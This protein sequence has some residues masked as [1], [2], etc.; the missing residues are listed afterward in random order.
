MAS[1]TS[2]HCTEREI[3]PYFDHSNRPD[4]TKYPK[5]YQE[6]KGEL[7]CSAGIFLICRNQIMCVYGKEHGKW[8]GP[9]G[10]KE[11]R[12]TLEQCAVRECLEESGINVKI[13]GRSTFYGPRT[14]YFV[15]T[16]DTIP[17]SKI[18]DTKEI[19]EVRWFTPEQ[20]MS[21]SHK[22]TNAGLK[23]FIRY[24]P[25][26]YFAM[27]PTDGVRVSYQ[28]P[29]YRINPQPQSGPPPPPDAWLDFTE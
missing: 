18:R 25:E 21:L 1:L 3:D 19:G 5:Y 26:K 12:E 9:K 15:E 6:Y 28:K 17:E 14:L 23:D 24:G 4:Q 8:G 11:E 13:T 2:H 7:F 29:M 20:L 22:D 10:H 16:V 27:Q